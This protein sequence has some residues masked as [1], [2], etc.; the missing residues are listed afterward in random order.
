MRVPLVFRI[1]GIQSRRVHVAASV[2]DIAPTVRQLMGLPR[3]PRVDGRS[4]VTCIKGGSCPKRPIYA[5]VVFSAHRFAVIHEGFKL[6]Q[7]F[8]RVQRLFDLDQDP[9]EQ[10]NL[11]DLQPSRRDA[12]EM[13]LNR[14][15][16]GACEP[17]R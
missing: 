2:A 16:Q 4:L 10:H 9:Q 12:M 17:V 13:L 11:A 15:R 5:E 3:R 1:P 7:S 8:P 6:I 14:C